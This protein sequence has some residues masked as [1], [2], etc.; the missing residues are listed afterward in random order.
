MKTICEFSEEH[1][2]KLVIGYKVLFIAMLVIA[3]IIAATNNVS[4]SAISTY[5]TQH[6]GTFIAELFLLSSSGTLGM[7]LIGLLI[8]KLPI[9]K[10]GITALVT[11]IVVAILHIL[12]QYSGI[13]TMFYENPAPQMPKSF[14]SSVYGMFIVLAI[15]GVCLIPFGIC[16][17]HSHKTKES[18]LLVVLGALIFGVVFS[19]PYIYV[20]YNRDHSNIN[21]TKDFK[22]MFTGVVETCLM[23]FIGYLLLHYTGIMDGFFPEIKP[24]TD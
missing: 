21:N 8:K 18:L 5:P 13:Y 16:E 1:F 22:T 15:L 9:K 19:V 24:K 23:F 6:P 10:L 20:A 7:V 17:L 14:T 11:F 12:Q 2:E 3:S 4:R